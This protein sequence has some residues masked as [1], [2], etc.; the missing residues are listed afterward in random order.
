MADHLLGSASTLTPLDRSL[1]AA[2]DWAEA[3]RQRES[4]ARQDAYE[5]DYRDALKARISETFDNPANVEALCKVLDTTNNPLKRI[6]NEVS[7][8]YTKR[9]ARK[10][11]DPSATQL[12]RQILKRAGDGV[13][14]P[15]LNRMVNLH[16]TVLVYVRPAHDSLAMRL[17]LPQDCTVWPDANDPT[18]PLCVE[19]R[20]CDPAAPNAKPRYW[21]FDRRPGSEGIR[22]Y[23]SQGKKISERGLPY[24][25]EHDRALIPFVAFH[26]E[27][28]ETFW[29]STSGDDLY[30]LT[31]M[32]GMWET[33][34][35][36]LI[37]TD[38]TR[39][40]WASGVIDTSGGND[41]GPNTVL[42]LRSPDGTPVNVGEFSSQADWDG[43][44]AQIKRKLENVLNNVGLVLPDTRTSG[45]PT[46]G[47][48][49]VVRSQ[50]LIKIQKAQ[51]PSY[52]RSEEAMYR[53]VSAVHNFEITNSAFPKITGEALPPMSEANPEVLFAEVENASTVEERAAEIANDK[54]LIALGLASP[55]TVFMRYFPEATEEEARAS[56]AKNL[57]ETEALKPK[58]PEPPPMVPGQPQQRIS[59]D[60]PSDEAEED[61]PPRK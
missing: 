60:E 51:I 28:R 35:N 12:Y 22:E 59:D 32:V 1:M 40:K 3:E 14:M 23:D 8:L 43:L 4:E 58:R 9:P 56:I 52:E 39:Q 33:W 57:A 34:I 19:F 25:D 13:T 42:P 24:R 5:D 46:S 18:M 49:L 16:N 29:D 55:V 31:I 30:E 50:G 48:A 37:R 41:G 27:A 61:Q 10:L 7:V 47:F 38:S 11:A 2:K 20:E 44:G 17:V 53:V 6:V 15:R 21:Q 54:E 45:D 36:H 26:R